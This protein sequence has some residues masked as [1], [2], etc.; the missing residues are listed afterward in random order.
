MPYWISD[1][2]QRPELADLG[3]RTSRG[4]TAGLVSGLVF[5]IATMGYVT[6]KGLPAV[7]PMID[8]ST[9]FH[10]QDTPVPSPDNVVVGLVTHLT[11]AATFGIVFALLAWVLPRRAGILLAAG[12]VYGLLLYVVNFQ[13]LGRTLFPW[14]TNPSGP[15]QGFE[16]FIHAVFGLLLVPFLIGARAAA[17]RAV[18]VPEPGRGAHRA[19]A[20]ERA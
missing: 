1:H 10:G 7:A 8:I 12:L 13:I 18:P 16:V 20:R 6:T 4:A 15:D 19:E 9:I 5:L 11:L 2:V 14:F 17:A 3:E